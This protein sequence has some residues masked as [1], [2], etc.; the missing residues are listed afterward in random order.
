[1]NRI[2][3]PLTYNVDNII[4]EEP[5]EQSSKIGNNTYNFQRVNIKTKNDDGRGKKDLILRF[6]KS[7]CL[8]ISDK[9][10]ADQLSALFILWDNET[11]PTARQ[12]KTKEVIDEIVNKSKEWLLT[13]ENKKL[14]KKPKLSEADV[15]K[16]NPLRIKTDENGEEKEGEAPMF[17]IRLMQIKAKKD[18]DGVDQPAKI[19]SRFFHETER[20]ENGK[21]VEIDPKTLIN[22]RFYAKVA[23]KVEDIFSGKEINL[24]WKLVEAVVKPLDDGSDR[25]LDDDNLDDEEENNGIDVSD[26]SV[27]NMSINDSASHTLQAS[28]DENEEENKQE[29]VVQV[30]STKSKRGKK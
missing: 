15:S 29:P 24:Q 22:K 10:G 13:P 2:C 26:A 21:Q 25:L 28:D 16:L 7:I 5:R 30:T 19:L 11:G 9:Y 8:G 27:E 23:V 4:F 18:K 17:A 3:D 6:D 1:M 20:D 14:L 12:L